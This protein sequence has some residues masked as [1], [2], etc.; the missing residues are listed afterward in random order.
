MQR[1]NACKPGEVLPLDALCNSAAR[2]RE[3]KAEI[4]QCP[5]G[6]AYDSVFDKCM[7]QHLARC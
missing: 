3:D 4:I 2:C 7:S 6:L 1:V 5:P